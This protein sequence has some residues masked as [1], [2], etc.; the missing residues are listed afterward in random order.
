MGE[1]VA[2]QIGV[3]SSGPPLPLLPGPPSRCLPPHRPRPG[4]GACS[5]CDHAY[6]IS[7]GS[8]PRGV[9]YSRRSERERERE[10]E[11]K[12]K[13]NELSPDCTPLTPPGW[14]SHAL[15]PPPGTRPRLSS[16]RPGGGG[17]GVL[18][19]V[20]GLRGREA[21][22]HPFY[23]PP[24]ESAE[25]ACPRPPLRRWRGHAQHKG[26]TA[27]GAPTGLARCKA[28]GLWRRAIK[29]SGGRLS[30]GSVL[31]P[32]LRFVNSSSPFF[33]F[34]HCPRRPPRGGPAKSIL[35]AL[36]HREE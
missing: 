20:H 27:A 19:V 18:S 1:R 26:A 5:R 14:A 25:G 16:P 33:C 35:P 17:G 36:A 2:L 28:A 22:T 29:E 13:T 24:T 32:G 10:R 15:P 9:K 31:S 12:Q 7:V 8:K 4:A 11:A 21:S 34:S 30:A 6:S 23:D 3:S